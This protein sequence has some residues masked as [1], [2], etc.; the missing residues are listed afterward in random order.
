MK[1]LIIT[2]LF[3]F[4]MVVA[5]TSFAEQRRYSEELDEGDILVDLAVARPLGV[6]GS[7]LGLALHGIGLLF[8]VP[9]ENFGDVGEVLVEKPLNYTFNRPLGRFED[10]LE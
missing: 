8:S 5:S 3:A 4:L 9:G 10:D 1:T 7:A 6:V 2:S